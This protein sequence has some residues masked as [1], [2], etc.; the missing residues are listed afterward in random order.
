MNYKCQSV[1]ANKLPISPNGVVRPLC[2]SCG[3][4]DCTNP[5]EYR[6]LSL[7]GV[8]YKDKVYMKATGPYFVIECEG[9]VPHD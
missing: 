8:N 5:I 9:Y 7:L 3:T 6:V 4:Q 1:S 2:N